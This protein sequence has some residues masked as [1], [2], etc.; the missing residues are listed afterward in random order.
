MNCNRVRE[1]MLDLMVSGAGPGELRDHVKACAACAAELESMRQTMA[2]LDRW[3]APADTSPYFMTRLRARMRE[4]QA[5]PSGWMQWFRKPALA[6]SLM[7]LMVASISLYRGSGPV[8][9]N[10]ASRAAVNFRPGTAVGDL[11]YLDRNH[12]LLADFELLDDLDSSP[13]LVQN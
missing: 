13:N 11:Q 9:E 10:G 1:Q 8:K 7:V 4:E 5:Q 6:V 3:Q 2:L 12:D